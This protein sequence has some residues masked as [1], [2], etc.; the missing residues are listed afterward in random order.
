MGKDDTQDLAS[1]AL[2]LRCIRV[3]TTIDEESLRIADSVQ[4]G[5]CRARRKFAS[6]RV[7]LRP[8]PCR[9]LKAVEGTTPVLYAPGRLDFQV[10]YWSLSRASAS[11]RVASAVE[12]RRGGPQ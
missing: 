3:L 9:W 10:W 12:P 5:L 11:R 6:A 7:L 1:E 2:R 8:R 4:A